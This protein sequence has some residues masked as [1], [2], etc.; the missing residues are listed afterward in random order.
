MSRA[1]ASTRSASAVSPPCRLRTTATAPTERR[2]RLL[3]P[4]A[5]VDLDIRR[6]RPNHGNRRSVPDQHDDEP[7]L[8]DDR[9]RECLERGGLPTRMTSRRRGTAQWSPPTLE[10]LG[11][12]DGNFLL[13]TAGLHGRIL[14]FRLQPLDRGRQVRRRHRERPGGPCHH[15][16]EPTA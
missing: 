6:S 13:Q 9:R 16:A 8:A 15:V 2:S 7:W 3:H 11:A 1:N 12:R 5:K 4:G 14:E 10:I